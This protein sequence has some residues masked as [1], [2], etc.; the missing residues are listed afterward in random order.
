MEIASGT[1][2]NTV[3]TPGTYVCP[4]GTTSNTLVNWPDPGV[5][6]R[7][8]VVSILR[9]IGNPNSDRLRQFV[10]SNNTYRIYQR[11]W[12]GSSWTDWVLQPTR[13]EVDDLNS[14]KLLPVYTFNSGS[15]PNLITQTMENNKVG[16]FVF[17]PG[18]TDMPSTISTSWAYMIIWSN[19]SISPTRFFGIAVNNVQVVPIAID[20]TS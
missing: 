17:L 20:R 6:G 16:L 11:S 2:I 12:V 15:I 8:E 10:Y 13:A 9:T 1:D 7:L 14:R 5:G 18:V 19:Y 4:N 3:L